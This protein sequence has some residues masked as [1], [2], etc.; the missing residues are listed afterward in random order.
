[1]QQSDSVIH[2]HV[3]ILFQILSPSRLLQRIETSSLCYAVGL[4]LLLFFFFQI[5]K[6]NFYLFFTKIAVLSLLFYLG[7]QLIL[8][9]IR[10]WVFVWFFFA[11]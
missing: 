9:N 4:H 5:F 6:I 3:S 8:V 1:M 11:F 10:V 7:I 2:I